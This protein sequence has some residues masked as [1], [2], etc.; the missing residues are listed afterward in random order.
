LFI[1]MVGKLTKLAS[2]VLMTHYTRSTV[3]TG[4]LGRLTRE[5]GG[6]ETLAAEVDRANTARHAY[7]LWDAAGMLAAAG[8][9]LCRRARDV[10]VRFGGLPTGVAMVDST[11]QVVVAATERS[12]VT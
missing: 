4:L 6:P 5:A 1:G 3:D 8:D 10:L 9:T 7:E 2:G 11:G 12:W